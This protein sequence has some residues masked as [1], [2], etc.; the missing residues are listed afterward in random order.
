VITDGFT[1]GNGLKQ[2][3][4]VVTYLFIIGLQYVVHE[5]IC[6]FFI[7]NFRKE[8]NNAECILILVIYWIFTYQ[9]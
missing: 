5:T 4:G 2:G 7:R 9:N 3:D 1:L 6:D 8:K